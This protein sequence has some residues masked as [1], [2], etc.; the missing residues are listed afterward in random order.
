MEVDKESTEV[1]EESTEDG[2]EKEDAA[3]GPL[4]DYASRLSTEQRVHE[5]AARIVRY[6]STNP[7]SRAGAVVSYVY[8][9]VDDH[10]SGGLGSP[11]NS[12]APFT[13]E[14]DWKVANWAKM[15]GPGS[16]AFSDLLAIGGVSAIFFMK[17]IG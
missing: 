7:H 6:S 5:C 12:W 11:R 17:K 4:F 8:Q 3:E 10:Y 15:R 14:I 2:D 1:N 9:S 16:T 13:L